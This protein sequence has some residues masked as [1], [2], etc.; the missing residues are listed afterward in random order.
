MIQNTTDKEWKYPVSHLYIKKWC[1]FEK[2]EVNRV[3]AVMSF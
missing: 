1:N 2:I 3:K